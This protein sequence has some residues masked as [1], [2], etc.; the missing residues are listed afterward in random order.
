LALLGPQPKP[1]QVIAI[2]GDHQASNAAGLVMI[3]LG[4][5]Q[6]LGGNNHLCF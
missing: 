6:F 4:E 2:G 5:N 3:G 1:N